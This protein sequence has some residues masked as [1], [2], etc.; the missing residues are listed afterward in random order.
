MLMTASGVYLVVLIVT[1]YLTRAT[2]K[3]TIG[4][5]SG[6]VAVAVVGVV[7]EGLAHARG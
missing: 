7:I 6:G 3:R 5:L 2:R 4:A 1:A